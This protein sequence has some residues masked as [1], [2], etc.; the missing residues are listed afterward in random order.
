VKKIG[1]WAELRRQGSMTLR[2]AERLMTKR[3][4]R[5]FVARLREILAG[6]KPQART[7]TTRD[8][9]DTQIKFLNRVWQMKPRT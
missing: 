3:F 5:Q 1:A 4:R 6:T 2:D 8:L 9:A 7:M